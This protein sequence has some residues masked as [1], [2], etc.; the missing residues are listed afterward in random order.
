MAFK[1]WG[2]GS[3]VED[4]QFDGSTDYTHIEGVE[5]DDV[6]NHITQQRVLRNV[7]E[8]QYEMYKFLNELARSSNEWKGIFKESLENEFEFDTTEDAV[9]VKVSSSYEE[10][11]VQTV[12]DVS[13]SL[14]GTYFNIN[15]PDSGYYI[16]FDVDGSSLDPGQAWPEVT[17]VTVNTF[18]TDA[19]ELSGDYFTISDPSNDYYV[20]IDVD[21]G[22]GDPSPGGTGIEVDILSTDSE[23]DVT[24]KIK[25]TVDSHSAFSAVN[26][27]TTITIT[28]DTAGDVSPDAADSGAGNFSISIVQQGQD[29]QEPSR[30]GIEVAINSDDTAETIADNIDT[31]LENQ[32][33]FRAD[34]STGDIVTITST[35]PGDADDTAD[36]TDAAYQTGFSFTTT[37]QGA[38]N[39]R[40]Y[41]RMAPGIA[42]V[43]EH[44]VV[45]KPQTHIAERQLEKIFGLQTWLPNPEYVTINYSY[46]YDR[47]DAEIVKR[48]SNGDLVTHT[49]DNS[50][51]YYDT[52]IELLEAI[53]NNANFHRALYNE[54]GTD[55]TLIILEPSLEI[56]S[57]DTYY[58]GLNSIGGFFIGNSSAEFDFYSFDASISGDTLS[59]SSLTDHRLFFQNFNDFRKNVFLNVPYDRDLST[60]VIDD[61]RSDSNLDYSKINNSSSWIT[62]LRQDSGVNDN[63]VFGWQEGALPAPDDSFSDVFY[64][65]KDVVI[66]YGPADEDK[67]LF[68][69]V[70]SAAASG[71]INIVDSTGSLPASET[72]GVT[73]F[74]KDINQFWRY[75]SSVGSWIPVSDPHKQHNAQYGIKYKPDNNGVNS[76]QYTFDGFSWKLD[77][78]DLRV[79]VNGI[80][81]DKNTSAQNYEYDI[82]SHN[83]IEFNSELAA[84]TDRITIEVITGG[85]AYYP[86]RHIYTAGTS[87][88]PYDGDLKI[89]PVNFEIQRERQTVYVDGV[90]QREAEFRETATETTG[91]NSDRIIDS[92]GSYDNSYVDNF[93]LVKTGENTGEVRQVS[94]V[95]DSS[96][97]VLDANLSNTTS[98]DDDYEIYNEYDYFADEY[99]DQVE[100]SSS[101]SGGEFVYIEESFTIAGNWEI[102][103][104]GN[105]FPSDPVFGHTFYRD[106]LDVWYKYNGNYWVQV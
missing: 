2:L 27:G 70:V 55:L 64:F 105:S 81:Q 99:L 34:Y 16:W 53:Y 94:S 30:T 85:E 74:V 78:T 86:D 59:I 21:D 11:E 92:S 88:S 57:N 98:V 44:I 95:P 35:V 58:I 71:G 20:W 51:T 43:N 73:Y 67:A 63:V 15:T 41:V 8:N 23:A 82:I 31:V 29:N 54:V 104:K 6:N 25:D 5:G 33:A 24:T 90:L 4:D 72:D 100:F 19:S 68:S 91:G 75:S 38:D 61:P 28:C 26:D 13:G 97:L 3:I 37:T 79:Y 69:N 66:R 96:T 47:Y 106:D 32:A 36:A 56:T 10:T 102:L 101:L 80:K 103:S 9:G 87:E 50:G 1:V 62:V 40:H 76:R 39:Y 49:F 93:V 65:N 22:S 84:N 60:E 12:D 45:S 17:D 42:F 48:N 83:T 52:G 46:Q 77:G 7:Y 18:D 14:G 89:F